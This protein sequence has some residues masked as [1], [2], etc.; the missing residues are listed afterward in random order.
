[1]AKQ[2]GDNINP[3]IHTPIKQEPQ[4]IGL[5]R[6]GSSS[7]APPTPQIFISMEH[8]QQEFQPSISLGI[9]WSK[10]T[11]DMS[12]RDRFQGPYGNHQRLESHQAVQTP[13]GKENRIRENK[14]TIQAIEEQLNQTRPTQ[15]DSGSQGAGQISS[16]VAS[17]H[18][19]TKKSLT[20]T[21]HSSQL[22][23]VS[24]RRQGYKVKNKTSFNQRKRE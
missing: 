1:M 8:G 23:A 13:G 18:S 7:S 19:E 6:Y 24:R 21:H 3:A 15:I 22:Q 20:R 17:H 9:T 16:P 5:E 10:L 14:A 11:E 4:T 2:C 12:R